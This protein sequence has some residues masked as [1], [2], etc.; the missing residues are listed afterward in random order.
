MSNSKTGLVQISDELYSKF[1]DEVSKL[2][3]KKRKNWR[4]FLTNK[5]GERSRVDYKPDVNEFWELSTNRQIVNQQYFSDKQTEI[6]AI[7]S[8]GEL[9]FE[10]DK[11]GISRDEIMQTIV[12]STHT[13]NH[14]GRV[15][16]TV[17]VPTSAGCP[18]RS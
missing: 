7:S 11:L 14:H 12:N 15:N 17:K 5:W 2:A 1:V 13:G 18:V 10:T 8:Y 6:R 3:I 16:F 9:I 4:G